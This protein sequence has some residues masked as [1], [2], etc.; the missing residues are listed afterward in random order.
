MSRPIGEFLYSPS[1][2]QICRMKTVEETRRIRL[3]LLVEKF[4]SM[5]NLCEALG[6][7][8]N[9]TATLTRIL[10]ANVRHDRDGKP[11]NMGGPMAR[12]IEIKLELEVGWMDTPPSYAELHGKSDPRAM[13][14]AVLESLPEQDW[15]AAV[16][17]LTALK[18]PP[19]PT[20]N[21][22]EH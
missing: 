2:F 10:N 15:P 11:Y 14:L 7:A 12:E 17:L 4:S 20:K 6:Y 9:E 19:I 3:R 5:A 1:G 13:A 16:R 21:G 22:T 8:R 18:E